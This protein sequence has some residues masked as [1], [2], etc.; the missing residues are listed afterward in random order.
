MGDIWATLSLTSVG[1]SWF[2]RLGS[3]LVGQEFERLECSRKGQSLRIK[4]AATR[5][6]RGKC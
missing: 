1:G 6:V 2:E 5:S 4:D 3:A